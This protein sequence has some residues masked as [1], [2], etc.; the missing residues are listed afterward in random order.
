LPAR[1]GSLHCPRLEIMVEFPLAADSGGP[2][3]AMI[4]LRKSAFNR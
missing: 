2:C 1:S 4:G 3:Q